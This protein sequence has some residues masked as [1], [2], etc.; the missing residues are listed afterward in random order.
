MKIRG[1]VRSAELQENPPGSDQ[2]ELILRVQGVGPGQPRTLIVPFSL[3]VE[4]ASLDPENVTGR[5]F[6]AEMEQEDGQ[7]WVVSRISFASRVLR[8]DD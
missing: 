1:L 3:L 7:R 6:E 8:Q 4:D 2:I 5:G